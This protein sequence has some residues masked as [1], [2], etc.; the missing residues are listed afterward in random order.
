VSTRR[1]LA[2]PRESIVAVATT[3]FGEHGYEGTTMRR[4]AEEVGVL[5]GSLYAHIDGKE[6]LLLEI[7]ENGM[8]R[9]LEL[10]EPIRV[11]SERADL[12][13][14]GAIRAHIESVVENPA[15]ALCIFHQWRHL[16]GAYKDR[17][18]EKRRAYE[19]VFSSIMADGVAAGVFR[20]TLEPRIAILGVLGALNWSMEWYSPQGPAGAEE[21][22][23]RI[24]D[25]LLLG[26]Q[27]S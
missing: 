14:R 20:D 25:A 11:S 1:N 26:L 23:E 13:L 24:A 19:Q 2:N 21:I 9:A 27:R 7:V 22:A 4:I 18:I 17:I 8:D 15:R 12:R 3:L 16:T 5:P 10:V 6:T